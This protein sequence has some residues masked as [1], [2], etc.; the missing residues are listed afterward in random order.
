MGLWARSRKRCCAPM[1]K[2]SGQTVA[3]EPL[4]AGGNRLKAPSKL[5]TLSM[6]KVQVLSRGEIVCKSRVKIQPRYIG[7]ER[8]I[9]LVIL[10]IYI[11]CPRG[12]TSVVDSGVRGID[13][14]LG[15]K[16]GGTRD[17]D[18]RIEQLA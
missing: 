16:A 12:G 4:D 18:R 15:F 13:K 9:V 8:Q 3:L 2:P 7:Q 5:N 11:L 1:L 17:P 14:P 6:P 10:R